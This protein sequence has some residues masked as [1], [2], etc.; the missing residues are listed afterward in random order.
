[1]LAKCACQFM[2]IYVCTLI[3]KKAHRSQK[4]RIEPPHPAAPLFTIVNDRCARGWRWPGWKWIPS[5]PNYPNPYPLSVGYGYPYMDV[6]D[7][8]FHYFYLYKCRF[9]LKK[10]GISNSIIVREEYGTW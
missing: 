2:S 7:S 1:M 5:Y 6:P 9:I 3:Q 8:I 4:A 10:Y